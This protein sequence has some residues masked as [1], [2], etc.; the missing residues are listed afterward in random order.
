MSNDSLYRNKLRLVYKAESLD[1][2]IVF[3]PGFLNERQNERDWDYVGG[4]VRKAGFDGSIYYLEWNA[5]KVDFVINALGKVAVIAKYA[6]VPLRFLSWPIL[7]VTYGAKWISYKHTA[8]RIATDIQLL[9]SLV[10]LTE[11]RLTFIG[12]SLGVSLLFSFLSHP[13]R[14]E[15]LL[16]SKEV[17]DILLLGG[18]HSVKARWDRIRIV[19]SGSFINFYS[20]RDLVL[21][22]LYPIGRQLYPTGSIIDFSKP[23]GSAPIDKEIPQESV[24]VPTSLVDY[25]L[26][27]W[28]ER[29]EL[30]LFKSGHGLWIENL[31]RI[32]R[33]QS[34]SA[35]PGPDCL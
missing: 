1:H 27:W 8:R 35:D 12:H 17:V 23:C 15:R 28:N 19:P 33:F 10:G 3:I 26:N 20:T 25:D 18:A 31:D 30:L 24:E 7:A 13:R 29:G 32:V 21:K 16:R 11:K 2:A 6:P 5:P 22:Y 4:K 14:R 9:D 34:G